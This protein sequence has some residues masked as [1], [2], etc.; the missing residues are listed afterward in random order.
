MPSARIMSAC[1]YK[2][3]ISSKSLGQ[4]CRLADEAAIMGVLCVG[5]SEYGQHIVISGI[6]PH[7]VRKRQLHLISWMALHASYADHQHVCCNKSHQLLDVLRDD[8]NGALREITAN[9]KCTRCVSGL[10][11]TVIVLRA[12]AY[13]FIGAYNM[14]AKNFY[15]VGSD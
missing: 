2:C 3:R 11:C 8:T 12:V 13:Y 7:H 6:R 1:Q 14:I 5:E 10:I 9:S 15:T 4:S